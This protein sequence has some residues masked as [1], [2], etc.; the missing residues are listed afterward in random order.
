MVGPIE[1]AG[2]VSTHTKELVN[3]LKK[4]GVFVDVYNISPNKE[5]LSTLSDIIKL[6]K[7]IIGLSVKLIKD[8]KKF[9]IIHI[10]SSGPL[11]GLL[12]AIVGVFW[13]KILGFKLVVTFHYSKT[14]EF[15][16]KHKYLFKCILNQCDRYI[17]V[18]N[19]QKEIFKSELKISMHNKIVVIPNG[20]NPQKFQKIPKEE[21]RKKLGLSFHDKILINVALLFEKKGQKYLIEAMDIIV[22]KKGRAD[23]KCFIIGNGR[24]K[25][26]LEQQISMLGLENYVKLVGAKPHNEIP[27]WMNASDLFVLP[28]LSE[29]FGI[30]QI[31]AMACGVPVVATINGG[32][33]EIITS[34]DYGLLV[35]PA[36]PEDLAEKILIALNKEWD[37]EKIRKYAEQFTWERIAER[38]HE[39]YCR[40]VSGD[41]NAC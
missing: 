26:K 16:K 10:Q 6:Y 17:V 38:I 14:E 31:E 37:K 34:E 32:S 25:E 21:A 39:I 20:Y 27:L 8:S 15:V 19:K 9:D 24:L 13:K 3:E 40:V 23:I 2:G 5:Y 22:H 1:K 12:P 33:E 11:G 30:V 36:N 28:S 29:S 4:L 35:E 18:S 41:H 7:R